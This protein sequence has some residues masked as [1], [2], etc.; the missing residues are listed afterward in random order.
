M[1]GV[2]AEFLALPLTTLADAALSRAR[3]LGAEYAAL[4]VVSTRGQ[5]LALQDLDL[6]TS[7]TSDD[8]GLAVRVVH[9]GC[10]GF[11]AGIVLSPEEA[12]RLAERAVEVARA[13][14]P[15]STERVVL[16][17][18]PA[19]PDRQWSSPY[20]T[21][22]F[23]VPDAEKV[24]TLLD[25]TERLKAG[26]GVA[27]TRTSFQAVRENVFYADLAGTPPPRRASASSPS[28]PR[29]RSTA[30][31]A[32]SRPCAP[33]RPPA[34]AGW[35]Y[36]TGADTGTGAGE[37]AEIPELLPRRSRRRRSSRPLRP[38]HRP[39]EP[40]AD[41]PR[42]DRARHRARPGARLRGG[43]RGDLVR[44][45]RQARHA[46]STARRHERHRRPRPPSTGWPRSAGTT[47]ASPA[48]T[49]DIVKDG[50]LVGYQLDRRDG[51]R[52]RASAGPTAAR[53]ADS[54]GHVPIQR[55]AN[56]VAAARRRTGPSTDDLI[57]RRRARAS[58]SSATSRWSIDMQRYNFQFTGQ[59]FYRDRER[60]AGRPA[61][62][63]R[64]PGDD[65][66]LLG[67]DG[68]GR[69]PA[70]LRAGRRV[71]LRQG[72]ARAG[73]AGQP[74][75]PVGAVPRRP[76]PQHGAGGRRDELASTTPGARRA[77]HSP[78]RPP[79]AA[80]SS[81]PTAPRPTCAGPTTRLTTNG[82]M[83][84]GRSP[85]SRPIGSGGGT[86]AGVVGAAR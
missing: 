31:P 14:R 52:S 68:G 71:Q 70:D 49:W 79:T 13:S 65:D 23:D 29:R 81:S 69:R 3:E 62:R 7:I 64:L 43:L 73:R 54:P 82:A 24:A 51:P 56:V 35:E 17:D 55:M 48:S 44:D 4:R 20:E 57:G 47:R 85:S 12:A 11:A 37:I 59:R 33:W 60:P 1:P 41:H 39:V 38:R 25:L 30:R 46:C 36:V 45:V 8:V 83:R 26:D 18:E 53:I 9:D 34:A 27:H 86:S 40:L 78:P 10:W 80:S 15:V 22:P 61:A 28:S 19:Y 66:R 50:V 32:R 77:R 16:A 5:F 6:E 21:D 2:N 75:L 76:H 42:V 67:L 63:R 72:P 58:T 84:L 74:R